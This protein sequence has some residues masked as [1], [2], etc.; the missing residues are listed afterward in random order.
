MPL[1]VPVSLAAACLQVART[2]LQKSLKN[3]VDDY[4]STWA[5]YVFALPLAPLILAGVAIVGG[6]LPA[7]SATYFL[8]CLLGGVA[9]II[10]TLMMLA[11]FAHRNFTVSTAF[12][13]TEGVQIALLGAYVFAEPPSPLGAVGIAVGGLGVLLMMPWRRRGGGSA[14]VAITTGVGCG[15]FFALTAW[16]IRL[17]YREIDAV[18]PLLAALCSLAVMVTMQ[19]VILFVVLLWR[20]ADFAAFWRARR[21][22]VAVG[23]T[24]LAGSFCWF[25]GFALTNPAYVKTLAQ[26]ELPLAY[27]LGRAAFRENVSRLEIAGMSAASAGAVLV[28]FA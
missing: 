13:K 15:L 10:A 4:F 28:A 24:S 11:L 1:W 16:C 17:S 19:A 27:L 6:G 26:I 7:F 12:A 23:A 20:K 8:F 3:D 25:A 2:G 21:R 22:A 18:P 9:Q 14:A 5:R